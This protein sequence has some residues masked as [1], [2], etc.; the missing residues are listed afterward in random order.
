ME[1]SRSRSAGRDPGWRHFRG[2]RKARCSP[3]RGSAFI[4]FSGRTS[5]TASN[6]CARRRETRFAR[7]ARRVLG[8]DWFAPSLRGTPRRMRWRRRDPLGSLLVRFVARARASLST[9]ADE[10]DDAGKQRPY[11]AAA[12]FCGERGH[13]RERSEALSSR[14]ERRSACRLFVERESAQ[15]GYDRQPSKRAT[16][17]PGQLA[18]S[19][20][21]IFRRSR[22]EATATIWGG[23]PTPSSASHGIAPAEELRKRRS[24][25]PRELRSRW[26][27]LARHAKP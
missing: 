11:G 21:S 13:A 27:D 3:T 19:I 26:S 2:R 20:S 22:V 24:R 14:Q 12:A 4:G 7:L 10:T 23:R 18:R 8:R 1:D 9:G 25:L 17:A 5:R 16:W 6:R 15:C